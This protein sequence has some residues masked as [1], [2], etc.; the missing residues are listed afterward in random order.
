MVDHCTLREKSASK[1][2]VTSAGSKCADAVS[3]FCLCDHNS[4][5]THTVYLSRVFLTLFATVQC[6]RG[7]LFGSR[8][9]VF[10]SLWCLCTVAVCVKSRY[11]GFSGTQSPAAVNR[12]RHSSHTHATRVSNHRGPS[13]PQLTNGCSPFH[14]P[15]ICLSLSL[16]SVF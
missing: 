6:N 13:R 15:V 3:G 10:P 1:S 11:Y 16:H 8:L 14:P 4:S 12:R 5:F 7:Q 2:N 9:P